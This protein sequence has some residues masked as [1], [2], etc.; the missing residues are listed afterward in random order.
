MR[1]T[2]IIDPMAIDSSEPIY[3]KTSLGRAKVVGYTPGMRFEGGSYSPYWS[4]LVEGD[5]VGCE[6]F[7]YDGEIVE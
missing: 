3:I 6:R 1:L 2:D 5:A 7:V 4:V